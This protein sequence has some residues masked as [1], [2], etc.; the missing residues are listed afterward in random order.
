MG[1]MGSPAMK[2][3]TVG[4]VDAEPVY[5]GMKAVLTA[6]QFAG[7]KEAVGGFLLGL[8]TPHHQE[9]YLRFS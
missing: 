6:E 4:R 5:E 3:K 9:K 1:P 2:G 8:S 7:Y